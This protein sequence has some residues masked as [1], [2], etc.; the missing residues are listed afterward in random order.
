[1]LS[2]AGHYNDTDTGVHIWR[3]AAYARALA[4]A[5]GWS[6]EQSDLL[7][8]AAPCT[9]WARL[10]SPITSSRSPAPHRGGVDH[11]AKS[12]A[13]RLRDL[14]A[15]RCPIFRMAAEIAL[16]HHEKWDGSGYPAGETGEGIPEA[17]RIVAIADVFDALS[18]RRP[19][20]EPWPWTGCW[21]PCAMVPASTSIPGCS[22]VFSRSCRRSCASRLN[23]MPARS[24]DY[25]MGCVR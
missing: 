16:H 13:H 15:I 20:K 2:E 8:L 14:E 21:P 12:P 1:M 17:S 4:D 7:E 6:P 9:T 19:Y 24:G 23:G 3:M 25:Q 5:A 18:V 10:V 22:P 11:H